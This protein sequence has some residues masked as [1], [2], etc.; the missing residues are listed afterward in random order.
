MAD[1]TPFSR[2]SPDELLDEAR[3]FEL[4]GG[5]DPRAAVFLIKELA[6]RYGV[7]LAAYNAQRNSQGDTP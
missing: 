2:L 7:Q 5:Y 1:W 4:H 3:R 6:Q